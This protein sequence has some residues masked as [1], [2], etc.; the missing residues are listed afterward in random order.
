[1]KLIVNS[2]SADAKLVFFVVFFF[3][4]FSLIKFNIFLTGSDVEIS[5]SDHV[6]LSGLVD[7]FWL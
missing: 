6:L 5:E 1:M 7:T 3:S 2:Y 4:K